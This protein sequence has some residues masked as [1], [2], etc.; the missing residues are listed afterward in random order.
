MAKRKYKKRVSNQ[1]SKRRSSQRQKNKTNLT[2]A[3][4][5]ILSILLA[6]LLYGNSGVVGIKLNE[7]L[8]GMIGLIKYV[9]PIGLF[10]FAIKIAT[11]ENEYSESKLLQCSLFFLS[12]AVLMSVVQINDGELN[13]VDKSMSNILKDAYS[14]GMQNSGGGVLGALIAVCF[15][16]LLGNVGAI[17]LSAG[18]AILLLIYVLGIDVSNIVNKIIENAKERREEKRELKA[19][20]E[21]EEFNNKLKDDKQSKNEQ[22]V[23]EQIKIN[24]G[25]KV[26][27][28]DSQKGYLENNIF[29]RNQN[30]S[31][32][33]EKTQ[34]TESHD[35]VEK[36]L[37]KTEEQQKEDKTKE[38]LQLEHAMMVEDENYEYPPIELL[39]KP[40]KK[41]L[42]GSAKAL[43]DTA[44][45]LQKTLYSFGV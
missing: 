24:F 8:G 11:D 32:N 14:T 45:K 35:N 38:V 39:S 42:K 16:K 5:I 2:V 23:G 40:E 44:T 3:G 27:N 10:I 22:E 30:K 6:V 41:A 17:V 7:I 43:T 19:E 15:V 18:I 29:K 31:D 36:S 4:L 1:T 25:D 28:D 12:L 33:Q 9:L 20:R 21:E 26:L 34:N 13:I 37:F